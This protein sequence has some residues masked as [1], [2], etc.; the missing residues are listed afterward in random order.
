MSI[1]RNEKSSEEAFDRRH[2]S[3]SFSLPDIISPI[4]RE[5]MMLSRLG[6]GTYNCS[7]STLAG[8]AFRFGHSAR[9]SYD[10]PYAKYM[11]LSRKESIPNFHLPE[12]NL[13]SF[14]PYT[15][16]RRIKKE[17]INLTNKLMTVR[18][19]KK[20]IQIG[21]KEKISKILND[22]QEKYEI[23]RK[24]KD[25]KLLAYK[26]FIIIS[27]L[28]VSS[29]IS[30]KLAKIKLHRQKISK[31]FRTFGYTC[32]AIGKFHFALRRFRVFK[33]YRTLNKAGARMKIWITKKKVRYRENIVAAFE[34]YTKKPLLR[35]SFIKF[36]RTV[37]SIQRFWRKAIEYKETTLLAKLTIFRNFENLALVHVKNKKKY[38]IPKHVIIKELKKFS[39]TKLKNYILAMRKYKQKCIGL[40]RSHSKLSLKVMTEYGIKSNSIPSIV[41]S[42]PPRVSYIIKRKRYTDMVNVLM[43]RRSLWDV[44][45]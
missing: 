40:E 16:L 34:N 3:P 28:A 12:I 38:K 25:F 13:E 2:L 44:N 7:S 31:F 4:A 27:I 9:F 41:Y 21:R 17:A 32:L 26:I 45:N 36:R 39:K 10:D 30:F 22:K 6:P 42:K 37:I 18:E 23:R 11:V 19:N 24:V 14:K 1:Q 43:H 35:I 20:K 29:Q 15:K 8:P 5:K 33:A